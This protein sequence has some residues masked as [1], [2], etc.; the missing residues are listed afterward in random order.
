MSY[1]IVRNEKLTRAQKHGITVAKLK[2]TNNLKSNTIQVGQK[3]TVPSANVTTS[4]STSSSKPAAS[5]KSYKTIRMSATAYT[6][7]CKGCS[8]ITATGINLKKNPGKKLK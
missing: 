4:K 6:A 1:A 5:K 8:G 7:S 3:L 2:T